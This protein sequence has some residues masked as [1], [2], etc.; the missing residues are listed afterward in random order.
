VTVLSKILSQSG[1]SL[2]DTYDVEGSIAGVENLES[3]DVHLFDEMGARVFS[4]R[5]HRFLVRMSPGAI[6]QNTN[7]AAQAGGFPDSTNRIL[8]VAVIVVLAEATRLETAQISLRESADDFREL[9]IM[10]WDIND[11]PEVRIRW[12]DDGAG[13]ASFVQLRPSTQMVPNLVTRF[14]T[15]GAMPTIEFRGI[16]GG[17]GAGTVTPI[18]IIDLLRPDTGNPAPGEPSSHGLPMPS[19]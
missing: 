8:S 3:R 13:V 2:A 5:L 15:A 9:P 19:W 7:F 12:D 14:G 1:I 6:N 18:A 11:D 4:E 17:F 16:S 10:V